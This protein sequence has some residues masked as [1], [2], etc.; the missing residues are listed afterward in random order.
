MRRAGCKLLVPLAGRSG[1]H[2]CGSSATGAVAG[3]DGRGV[4]AAAH[5]GRQNL[6]FVAESKVDALDTAQQP[7]C[8]LGHLVGVCGRQVNTEASAK[9]SVGVRVSCGCYCTGYCVLH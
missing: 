8:R 9:R 1:T 5:S 2:S 3:S 4:A 7:V 6:L